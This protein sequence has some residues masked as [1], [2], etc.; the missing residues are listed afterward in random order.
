MGSYCFASPYDTVLLDLREESKDA[1]PT[2]SFPTL[3]IGNPSFLYPLSPQKKMNYS[4][5][6]GRWEGACA[7]V[8]AKQKADPCFKKRAEQVVAFMSQQK[9]YP[10]FLFQFLNM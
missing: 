1:T 8:R 6:A 10:L 2:P 3:V 4:E 7:P 9:I 5:Q